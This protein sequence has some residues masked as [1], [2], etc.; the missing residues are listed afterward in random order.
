M[1]VVRVVSRTGGWSVDLR[2]DVRWGTD[3]EVARRLK[4]RGC[5]GMILPGGIVEVDADKSEV[6]P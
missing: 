6:K 1:P 4:A 2:V 5:T 3:L